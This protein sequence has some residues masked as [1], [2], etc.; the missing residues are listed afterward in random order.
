MKNSLLLALMV[1]ILGA[2]NTHAQADE[3]GSDFNEPRFPGCEDISDDIQ[4]RLDCAEMKMLQFIFSNLR[5]PDQARANGTQ[6]VV[7]VKFTVDEKGAL[8]NPEIIAG[9]G[10][11]CDEEVIRL[12]ELMPPWIP[13]EGED[14]NPVSMDYT[15]SVR[16]TP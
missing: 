11:G 8:V 6:G 14:G 7:Q 1:F 5:V 13:A 2:M 12:L 10:D 16:F 9:L 3:A 4:D 15:L